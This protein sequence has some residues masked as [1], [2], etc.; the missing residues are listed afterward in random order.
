M[1]IQSYMYPYIILNLHLRV[2]LS[3]WQVVWKVVRWWTVFRRQHKDV[4]S[5]LKETENFRNEM[6]CVA[7]FC[8]VWIP[9][10]KKSCWCVCC[11]YVTS[12]HIQ[13]HVIRMLSSGVP[14]LLNHLKSFFFSHMSLIQKHPLYT[15]IDLIL[16]LH[17]VEKQIIYFFNHVF[18]VCLFLSLAQKM[19]NYCIGNNFNY[20]PL[21]YLIYRI[22]KYCNQP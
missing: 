10:D 13:I 7:C 16:I 5:S 11:Y 12:Y 18:V 1:I 14:S 8:L 2:E 9:L 20:F 17:L 21:I 3:C 19:S 4:L 6:F 15:H 22:D